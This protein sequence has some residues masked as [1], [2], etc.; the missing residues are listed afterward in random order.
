MESGAID[1]KKL[2][3]H[4]LALGD[5]NRGFEMMEKQEGLKLLL[6]PNE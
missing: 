3:S 4:E 2:I 6:R 1:N 5:W